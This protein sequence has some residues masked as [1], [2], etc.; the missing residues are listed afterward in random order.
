MMTKAQMPDEFFAELQ[1]HLPPEQPVGVQGGRPR[2]A[3]HIV[4]K[5]IWFVLV[6]G[7]RWEDVPQEFSCSGRTAH[8]RLQDWE[9]QGIWDHLHIHLLKLLRKA[10]A[11][12]NEIV[13]VDSVIVRAFGGGEATG[14]SPVDRRKPGSKHTVMV[15][16]TGVP[17][18]IRTVGANVSDQNE[19]LPII[20]DFPQVAGKPGRPKEL[21]D[22]A[23]ADRGYDSDATRALLQ[24]LGIE[25][26][27]ARRRTPHGSGLGKVRWVV[28][29]T[30]SWIKGLR[31]M[32]VRYDRLKIVRDAWSTLAAAVVCYHIAR[33]DCIL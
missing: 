4:M 28:E 15:D 10:D 17:L 9:K 24:W 11:L 23:Y 18:A 31:R 13:I 16:G 8:R 29:R 25:P 32:R 30:I 6:T 3:H 2:I 22:V 19:I 33:H 26:K 12:E 14:P 5:V 1:P 7:C 21:P 20:I 27:I